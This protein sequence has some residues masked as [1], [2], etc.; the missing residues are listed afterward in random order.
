MK[1]KLD[2]S[3]K[4]D[5][6]QTTKSNEVDFNK[7]YFNGHKFFDSQQSTAH[8]EML[9]TEIRVSNHFENSKHLLTKPRNPINGDPT[10]RDDKG[11]PVLNPNL[12]G[13]AFGGT[14]LFPESEQQ[15]EPR[16]SLSRFSS[17]NLAEKIGVDEGKYDILGRTGETLANSLSSQSLFTA[18]KEFHSKKLE[19]VQ[20]KETLHAMIMKQKAKRHEKELNRQL[21]YLEQ[22]SSEKLRELE[23][24]KNTYKLDD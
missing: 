12:H 18:C 19:V 14:L 23:Y 1:T 17:R 7:K 13:K 2:K 9:R 22:Q 5:L 3:L 6:V 16:E 21:A 10:P 24:L 4:K 20:E 15:F 8:K 11:E